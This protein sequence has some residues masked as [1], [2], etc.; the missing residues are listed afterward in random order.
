M[1]TGKKP[2]PPCRPALTRD[3]RIDFLPGKS[4]ISKVKFNTLIIC[5]LFDTEAWKPPGRTGWSGRAD[6]VVSAGKKN[7]R[8]KVRECRGENF[9][10]CSNGVFIYP[11]SGC[12]GS[13]GTRGWHIRIMNEIVTSDVYFPDLRGIS[14]SRSMYRFL[15]PSSLDNQP[16][17]YTLC[18]NRR[19]IFLPTVP[20][21]TNPQTCRSTVRLCEN[22]LI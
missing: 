22:F 1:L 3:C 11:R 20:S 19:A 7:L 10:F 18:F 21:K 8:K 14:R 4:M 15:L 5:S 9:H 17:E 16:W 12:G 2:P 13:P 6:V